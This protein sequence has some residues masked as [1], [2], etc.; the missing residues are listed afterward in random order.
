MSGYQ[1][2]HKVSVNQAGNKVG[3]FGIPNSKKSAKTMRNYS[4]KA[5][6]NAQMKIGGMK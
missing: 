5:I 3:E 4:E 1:G 2:Y 6:K